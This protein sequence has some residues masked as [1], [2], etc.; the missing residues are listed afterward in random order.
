M[1]VDRCLLILSGLDGRKPTSV[2]I[3]SSKPHHKVLSLID[4]RDDSKIIRPRA[5]LFFSNQA[6]I[7]VRKSKPETYNIMNIRLQGR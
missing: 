6:L 3:A 4:Y 2:Y 7:K 5:F 1:S